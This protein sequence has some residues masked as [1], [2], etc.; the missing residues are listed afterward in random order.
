MTDTGPGQRRGARLMKGV[1]SFALAALLAPLCASG[2]SAQ[3]PSIDIATYAGPDRT[4]RLVEGAK[5]EGSLM[6]YSSLTNEE[7]AALR[8]AFE[9]KYG[10]KL[11]AWRG[12]GESIVRR[13]VVEHRA[14]RYEVDVAETSG[15]EM[16]AM[17][18]EKLFRE[19]KLP[20]FAD[21]VPQAITPH[22]QWIASRL[23]IFAQSYNTNLV[24]ASETP[25]TYEDLLDPRWKGKL[26]IE[27]DDANWFMTIAGAM[28]EEK[29][30]KL[31][32]DIVA[33]NGVSVRKGH[34]LLANLVASGE[35][36]FALTTY[37]NRV[38]LIKAG[39]A[40]VE[41][42][43]LPPVIALPSGSGVMR[44]APHPYAAVLFLDFLLSDGQEIL[45]KLGATP[46]NRKVKE[47][48]SDLVFVDIPK[49]LDEGEK[50]T[51]L[52]KEVFVNQAR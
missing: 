12:D 40:P 52:F 23:I 5:R 20:V 22:R 34:T 29:G 43:Y 49:L 32:R 11:N 8:A 37:A 45:A 48:R 17:T 47:P 16:E 28:G 21:L 26:G 33:R 6:L 2:A 25:K 51:R 44:Q 31:F 42:L 9:A 3:A 41:G 46:S 27:A 14:G 1:R 15:T 18:R 19:L 35:V 24:K 39:G 7:I 36:P 10:V 50:W 13:A 4:Q 30:I 38:D